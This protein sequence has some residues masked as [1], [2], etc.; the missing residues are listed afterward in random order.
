MLNP[1]NI[2]TLSK[3]AL[4]TLHRSLSSLWPNKYKTDEELVTMISKQR[5]LL[6][7]I[8]IKNNRLKLNYLTETQYQQIRWL[9]TVDENKETATKIAYVLGVGLCFGSGAL[10]WKFKDKWTNKKN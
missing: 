8:K 1:R 7:N 5:E 3:A 9:E 2:T 4:P 6:D 10:A